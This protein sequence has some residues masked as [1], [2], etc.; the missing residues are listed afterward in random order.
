M[1]VIGTRAFCFSQAVPFSSSCVST[2]R[3]EAL[4][5]G[6][7]LLTKYFVQRMSTNEEAK[8]GGEEQGGGSASVAMRSR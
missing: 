7:N 4:C 3:M 5:E 1:M 8:K 2:R 6:G